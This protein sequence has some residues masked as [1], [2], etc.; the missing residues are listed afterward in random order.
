VLRRQTR[1]LAEGMACRLVIDQ[2]W[3]GRAMLQG[4][5]KHHTASSKQFM[6]DLSL[7]AL[8][9]GGSSLSRAKSSEV[10]YGSALAA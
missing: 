2:L 7:H 9:V 6:K 3:E 5:S 8:A 4:L 10:I 1:S